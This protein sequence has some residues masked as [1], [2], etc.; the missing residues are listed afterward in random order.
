[1]NKKE[2]YHTIIPLL[3][4]CFNVVALCLLVLVASLS[5]P[6][7]VVANTSQQTE[8]L[9]EQQNKQ[10]QQPEETAQQKKIKERQA[11]RKK[12]RQQAEREKAREKRQA[13]IEAQK[14]APVAISAVREEVQRYMGYEILTER[15]L[16]LPYDISMN[17]N[18]I[19]MGGF[20]DISYFLL[21]FLPVILLLGFLKKPLYGFL[22]MIASIVLLSISTIT[23]YTAKRGTKAELNTQQA[24]E[25]FI[26]ETTFTEFPVSY[27]CAR[28]YRQLFQIYEPIHEVIATYSGQRDY[29]TY[30]LLGILFV[31]FFIIL[32]KRIKHHDKHT[33]ALIYFLY[34]FC[35]VW[36]ILASGIIWYGFLMIAMGIVILVAALT[37]YQASASWIRKGVFGLFMLAAILW[38]GM[39]YVY[40]ISNHHFVNDNSANLLFDIPSVKYQMGIFDEDD[41]INNLLP[42]VQKA[43]NAINTDDQAMVYRVGTFIPYFIRENDRR[44]LQDNQLGFFHNLTQKFQNRR[45]ITEALK[46]SG[47][48][49][50]L[51]DLNT[52]S[53]DK[54]P[55]KTLTKKFRSFLGYL[56]GNED[57]ELIATNRVITLTPSGSPNAIYT[58]GVFGNIYK[59]GTFAVYKIK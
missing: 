18:V 55:E 20:V 2:T 7:N 37:K 3:K 35:F 17:T 28:V 43:I 22:I 30:P 44:V 9:T 6:A 1:M 38:V 10:S 8:Q 50:I 48:R 4:R 5:L 26:D 36:M 45:T 57:L 53:I 34:L 14:N 25:K 42:G 56:F 58:H 41:F 54:T 12:E 32:Q 19:G 59:P 15:Y 40:R 23:A 49:Y 31:L 51:V 27:I 11:Q 21:M 24:I 29:I 46:A 52:A 16:S 47:Y 39:G 33:I 13:E